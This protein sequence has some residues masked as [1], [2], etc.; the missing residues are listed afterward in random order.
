MLWRAQS[1]LGHFYRGHRRH[2]EAERAFAAAR[3]LLAELAHPLVDEPLRANFLAQ[4]LALMPPPRKLSSRRVAKAAFG[5][6]TERER[7]VA[8]LIAQGKSNRAIA[9]TLVITEATTEKHVVNILSKL[10]FRSRAQIA[11]WA[12]SMRLIEPAE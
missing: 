6:L 7:Q 5:G 10:A 12:V 2:D 11:A 1:V 9:E 8:A 4:S 3:A